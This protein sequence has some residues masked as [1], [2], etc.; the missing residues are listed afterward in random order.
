[1][2]SDLSPVF[3]MLVLGTPV[4]LLVMFLPTL[5]ELWKPRD[6]GPRLMMDIANR[7]SVQVLPIAHLEN[8]EEN[9]GF[10]VNPAQCLV[11]ILHVLP[12]LDA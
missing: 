12:S 3:S 4:L 8:I 7:V 6:A 1:M 11:R 5:L 10:V 9:Q 2:I